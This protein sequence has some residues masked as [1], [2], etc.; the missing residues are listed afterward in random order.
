MLE[1]AS[2]QPCV[3][4]SNATISPCHHGGSLRSGFH[5]ALIATL[6][7]SGLWLWLAPQSSLALWLHVLGG[8]VLSAALAPWLWRHVREG[9][10]R[11]E[12]QAFTLSSWALLA[13][14]IVLLVSGLAMAAPAAWWFAGRVWFPEHEVSDALSLLHFWGAWFAVAG[15]GQHLLMRHWK[16]PRS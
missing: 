3:A 16:A 2:G 5:S 12:R 7:A 14:W 4:L 15:L 6:F 10:A 1:R 11:S 13:V 8:I 9:L